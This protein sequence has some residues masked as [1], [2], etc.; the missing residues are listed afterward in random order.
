MEKMCGCA[1]YVHTYAVTSQPV[2]QMLWTLITSTGTTCHCRRRRA[3]WAQCR[4]RTSATY[5]CRAR[6]WTV[7]SAAPTAWGCWTSR[8]W[9]PAPPCSW[10][11]SATTSSPLSATAG[12]QLWT[13]T[14][15]LSLPT[16]LGS[17]TAGWCLPLPP[18]CP[19]PPQ[20]LSRAKRTAGWFSGQR[21]TW[22]DQPQ[23]GARTSGRRRTAG[24]VVPRT[25]TRP[26]A[27]TA[28]TLTTTRLSGLCNTA[29][30]LLC[31]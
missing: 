28:R 17:T 12:A 26:P 30:R 10:N 15:T 22:W 6:T 16:A 21:V 13:T 27:W 29:G 11:S 31:R 20:R 24:P 7:W 1:C 3:P 9:P 8:A 14:S 4:S 23:T 18:P 5:G 19:P 2:I 25:V